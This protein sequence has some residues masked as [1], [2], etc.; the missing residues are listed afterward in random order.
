MKGSPSVVTA[1]QTELRVVLAARGEVDVM[2]T[3]KLREAILSSLAD[4]PSVLV[5]DLSATAFASSSAIGALIEAQL[6]AKAATSVRLVVP[7]RVR[8]LLRML[9]LDQQFEYRDTVAKALPETD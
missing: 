9:G 7:S 8:R 6:A 5:I 3:P 2:T 4:E 1:R